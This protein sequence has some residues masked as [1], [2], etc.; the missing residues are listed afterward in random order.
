MEM[1][2]VSLAILCSLCW[3][4][5]DLSRKLLSH[6]IP[7]VPLTILIMY[8]QLPFYGAGIFYQG[9]DLTWNEFVQPAMVAGIFNL[10]GNAFFV[11]GV[12]KIPF[13][14]SIPLLAFT[15]AFAV[16]VGWVFLGETLGPVALAGIALIVMGSLILTLRGVDK[17]DTHKYNLK[18]GI[19]L[20]LIVSFCWA[21][22]PVFDKIA[23]RASSESF[24]AFFQCLFIGVVLNIFLVIRRDRLS[25]PKILSENRK[26]F[27]LGIICAVAALSFQLLAI[28]KIEVGLVESLKRATELGGSLLV[29]AFFFKEGVNK[30][31]IASLAFLAV[32]SVLVLM[33]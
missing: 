33:R 7:V 22:T 18:L 12:Q 21:V 1:I 28:Q 13:S 19:S 29:G 27:W 25:A 23:L 30:Y 11:W 16:L 10:F 3:L 31:K 15:P 9:T 32:G 26:P 17:A 14:I 8:A 2:G 24:H 20:I 6:G 5:F 4:G